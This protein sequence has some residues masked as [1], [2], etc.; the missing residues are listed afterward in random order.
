MENHLLTLF[1]TRSRKATLCW[2]E[3]GSQKEIKPLWW[4]FQTKKNNVCLCV[5]VCVFACASV[6]VCVCVV[7][8]CVC[9]HAFMPAGSGE[10]GRKPQLGQI[11]GCVSGKSCQMKAAPIMKKKGQILDRAAQRSGLKAHMGT[12]FDATLNQLPSSWWFGSVEVFCED[13]P[14]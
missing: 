5:C 9:A 8:V 7:I 3:R 2:I 14:T 11:V 1:L 6:R 13:L 10:P 12:I 4:A